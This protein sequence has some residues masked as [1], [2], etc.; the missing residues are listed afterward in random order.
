MYHGRPPV[1]RRFEG[2]SCGP[3]GAGRL[4]RTGAGVCGSRAAVHPTITQGA[5]TSSASSACG[6]GRGWEPPGGS[7]IGVVSKLGADT[8]TELRWVCNARV[9]DLVCSEAGSSVGSRDMIQHEIQNTRLTAMAPDPWW[10]LPGPFGTPAQGEVHGYG[11]T[12]QSQVL[13]HVRM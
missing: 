8:R 5:P 4:A 13:P 10:W 2:F 7:T 11:Q 1:V 12:G 3:A 6:E 9:V